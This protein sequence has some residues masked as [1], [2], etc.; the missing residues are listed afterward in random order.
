MARVLILWLLY[1]AAQAGY[2]Q[3]THTSLSPFS[4]ANL[5]QA[6]LMYE[7]LAEADSWKS[8]PHRLLLR[9]GDSSQYVIP[10]KQNLTLTGDLLPDTTL[11]SMLYTAP[12]V[13]AVKRF[14]QRHGLVPDGVL[15]PLTV[16]ALNV[17]PSY[18]LWQLQQ[19][20]ARWDSFFG[21]P[22][23]AFVVINIP[24]YTLHVLEDE[25]Q[26]MEMRVIVGKPSLA[27]I[28]IKSRLTTVV[29]NPYWYLPTSIAVKEIVP[30]LRRN[31]GYLARKNMKLEKPI[32]NSWV[33]VNPWRVDWDKIDQTNYTYRIV[34][35]D[36][37]ENELGQVK[38][39]FPNPIPQYLH[40]TPNK[41][42]FTYPNRAF[43]HGCIRLERPIELA[44]YLLEK[45]SGYSTEKIDK[46]WMKSKPNH[47]LRVHEPL[48][49]YIVYLTAWA[50][51][52]QQVQ[53]RD[54]VY[55]YDVMPHL[56]LE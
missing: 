22:A 37:S 20:F 23:P 9:P 11:P 31:P 32:G 33:R 4:K 43:S 50:D 18:R 41:A 26:V 49:L 38:F 8:L 55:G 2:A 13:A 54:D 3:E 44:Y 14:Q 17:P 51:G 36:G 53:F 28:P 42:L 1:A 39:P 24:D 16:R 56:T 29:L 45:G 48:P 25:R 34:Q 27:T 21:D 46:I 10:L 15:G 7:A 6:I 47:Y 40:D 12:M 35:L 5:E 19:S 52:A 30:I